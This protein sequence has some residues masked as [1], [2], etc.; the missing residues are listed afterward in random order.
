M[1]MI[2]DWIRS[3]FYIDILNKYC[4]N[5]RNKIYYISKNIG[6]YIST[7]NFGLNLDLNRRPYIRHNA[8]GS[9]GNRVV[10][11]Q[12]EVALASLAAVKQS[13]PLL[14]YCDAAAV[15]Q[16]PN[17]GKP[18]PL[19]K[20]ATPNIKF[21]PSMK[22]FTN[23][24][25]KSPIEVYRTLLNLVSLHGENFPFLPYREVLSKIKNYLENR[26]ELSTDPRVSGL[27]DRVAAEIEAPRF[28]ISTLLVDEFVH[29]FPEG[30]KS[31]DNINEKFTSFTQDKMLKPVSFREEDGV[32]VFK[33]ICNADLD[34]MYFVDARVVPI[35]AH[36]VG[37]DEALNAEAYDYFSGG[38]RGT[39]L[40]HD[41][42]HTSIMETM[43]SKKY[44]DALARKSTVLSSMPKSGY[45][46][47]AYLALNHKI[48]SSLSQVKE[49][50][51]KKAIEGLLFYFFHEDSGGGNNYNPSF[52]N[53]YT[54]AYE[55]IMM[56]VF[57]FSHN[58]ELLTP[59]AVENGDGL[60]SA[61]EVC[62][63]NLKE[64]MSR[65]FAFPEEYKTSGVI[66]QVENA[67]NWLFALLN[68]E[69]LRQDLGQAALDCEGAKLQFAIDNE[70]GM[71]AAKLK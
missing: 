34:L 24:L 66:A 10:Q 64:R 21:T 38:N 3:D 7:F 51:L 5:C 31:G 65:G 2:K 41:Q 62:A 42:Q 58:K 44:L 43:E 71:A 48:K 25:Q 16:P 8:I 46:M 18:A 30:T 15:R 12:K 14:N 59:S 28:A 57:S 23:D 29:L 68:E 32:I 69:R 61:I 56:Q 70:I 22:D 50:D 4:F 6:G 67:K 27:H 47:V 19:T 35:F 39:F 52:V 60:K 9:L 54:I 45:P 1:G 33:F 13:A 49:D 11:P 40:N 36:G 37:S 55:E 53:K 26:A 63:K 17:I 20:I